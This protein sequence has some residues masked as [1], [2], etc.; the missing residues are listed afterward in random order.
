MWWVDF[1]GPYGSSPG[2]RRP[3]AVVSSDR[4]NRSDIAT[5]VVATITSNDRLSSMPG[6]VVLPSDL[7]PKPSVVN[8]TQLY[9]VDRRQLEEKITD[10]PF[11][12]EGKV[13]DGI[14]LVLGL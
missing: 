8:V 13:D 9:C 4:F 5:V 3:A 12:E 11:L 14:R 1:G 10:L 2:Y 7:L 6:N